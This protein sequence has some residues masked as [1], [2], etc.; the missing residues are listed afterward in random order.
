MG[1]SRPPLALVPEVTA[2]PQPLPKLLFSL[3][4]FRSSDRDLHIFY[5]KVTRHKAKN[6]G[7]CSYST[8]TTVMTRPVVSKFA[9]LSKGLWFESRS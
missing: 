1:H 9:T 4:I 2:L 6:F 3:S 7:P 8:T 5:N